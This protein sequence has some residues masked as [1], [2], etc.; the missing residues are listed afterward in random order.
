MAQRWRRVGR[1]FGGAADPLADD[2]CGSH[3]AVPRTEAGDQ[4]CA[5]VNLIVDSFASRP[6][7]AAFAFRRRPTSFRT[8]RMS[9]LLSSVATRLRGVMTRDEVQPVTTPTVSADSWCSLAGDELCGECRQ[10]V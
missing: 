4:G 9:C 8:K 3:H 5:F 2:S 6:D 10:P 7:I 1:V